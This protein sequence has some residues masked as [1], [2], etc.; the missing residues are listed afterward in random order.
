M[1]LVYTLRA[2]GVLANPISGVPRH[3][4]IGSAQAFASI[5]LAKKHEAA[6]IERCTTPRGEM[7]FWY[8]DP[9]TAEVEIQ[10]LEFV[11]E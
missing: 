10:S 6:F 8:L 11:E 4:T 1:K 3:H 5:E 2:K 7:D 9:E